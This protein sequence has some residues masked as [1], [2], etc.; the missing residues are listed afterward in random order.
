[1]EQKI[2]ALLQAQKEEAIS[3]LYDNYSAILYGVV[4]RIVRS[5]DVAQDVLQETF[6]KVW[7]HGGTYDATKGRLMTWLLNIA[8]H[9]AI[10]VVRSSNWK[11]SRETA[12]L[13]CLN[14]FGKEDINTE[15][16]GLKELADS[17]DPKYRVLIDLIYFQGY[18][19]Q[20]IEKELNIPLGTVKTRLRMAIGSLRKAFGERADNATTHIT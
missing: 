13:T 18:T 2:I 4:L 3:L 1:M 11:M 20:E 8:R 16:I 7:R 10:D 17:L 6:V 5:P 19:H 14:D 12:D 9:T 15:H